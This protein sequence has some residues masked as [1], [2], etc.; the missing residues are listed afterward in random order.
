[1]SYENLEHATDALIHVS[2]TTLEDAFC[3]AGE[4]VVDTIL[5]IKKIEEKEQK[6]VVVKGKDLNYLLYNW[7]EEIITIVITDGFAIRKFKVNII[8]NDDYVID[9]MLFG[10]GLD[11]K[12]HDF[13]VEI[14]SPTFH[15]MNIQIRDKVEMEYLL[16]L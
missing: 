12:K 11:I 7:L 10:E 1:M 5:D 16:D 9:A 3:I 4:S 8:E 14:K 13:K 6:N 15:L 2:A